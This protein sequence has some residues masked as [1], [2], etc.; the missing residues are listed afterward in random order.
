M[1]ALRKQ[2]QTGHYSVGCN[3]AASSRSEPPDHVVRIAAY[4]T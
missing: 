4:P 3:R 1:R 2:E